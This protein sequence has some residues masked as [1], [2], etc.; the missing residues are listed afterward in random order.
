MHYL[1][2]QPCSYTVRT[3][4]AYHTMFYF[5]CTFLFPYHKEE[6]PI[7]K[8]KCTSIYHK[9][10][11]LCQ[12]MLLEKRRKQKSNVSQVH[13]II[14]RIIILWLYIYSNVELVILKAVIPKS[15]KFG[16]L[17]EVIMLPL[18]ILAQWLTHHLLAQDIK[19]P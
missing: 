17:D 5:E 13:F 11:R 10:S 3:T 6:V 19:C 4:T 16:H 18:Y 12:L 9:S 15:K 8:A 1:F 2:S 7:T 14:F